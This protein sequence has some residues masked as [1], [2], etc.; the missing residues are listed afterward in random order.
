MAA[1]RKF[2]PDDAALSIELLASKGHST[3]GLAKF[4]SV[5]RSVIARWFQDDENLEE[6][7][8]QGRDSYRQTLEE[9]II[10][11]TMANK[12]PAGLIYL[13]KAKFK[14][15][16]QPS[17]KPLVD[18]S[19]NPVQNVLVIKDLGTNEEW[20]AKAAAQQRALIADCSSPVQLNTPKS[21]VIDAV[22]D[23]GPPIYQPVTHDEE[24]PS[25]PS[26][27]AIESPCWRARA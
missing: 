13:L 22:R 14:M 1:H 9:Q 21:P 5:S 6:C 12:N 10:Q 2:P 19:V 7:Y 17:S 25:V 16:D 3:I 15:Y 11:M 23:Y 20:A 26:P 27:S 8:E 24:L 18:L 4:F